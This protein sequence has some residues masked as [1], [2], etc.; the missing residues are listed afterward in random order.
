MLKLMILPA[1]KP[2]LYLLNRLLFP[3]SISEILICK[4]CAYA[5][6]SRYLHAHLK[7]DQNQLPG[8]EGVGNILTLE[9]K[10]RGFPLVDPWKVTVKYALPDA[11]ALPYLAVHDVVKSK[12]GDYFVCSQAWIQQHI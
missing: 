10:L 9:Q 3:C 6:P 12:Q 7:G 4:P 5:I 11:I 1:L 2:S 8:L